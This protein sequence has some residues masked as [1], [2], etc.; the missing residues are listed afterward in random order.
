[1]GKNILAEFLEQENVTEQL[2]EPTWIP[3]RSLAPG[4]P[5]D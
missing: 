1:M 5:A 3:S 4:M 2:E